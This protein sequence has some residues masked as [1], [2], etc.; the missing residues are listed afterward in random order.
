MNLTVPFINEIMIKKSFEKI[1]L[2]DPELNESDFIVNSFKLF[3]AANYVLYFTHFIFAP[4]GLYMY[5]I[6]KKAPKGTL[7]VDFRVGPKRNRGVGGKIKKITK[8]FFT[9]PYR[10]YSLSL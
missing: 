6:R 3:Y 4:M 5:Q 9:I 2:R 8:I 7:T 1:G 10:M